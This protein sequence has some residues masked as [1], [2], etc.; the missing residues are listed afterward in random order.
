MTLNWFSPLP[1]ARSAIASYTAAVLP[2]LMRHAEVTVWSE[3]AAPSFISPAERGRQRGGS[4]RD[5]AESVAVCSYRA[6]APP[7][8]EI[9]R[10]DLSIYHI[11]NHA[12]F[13]G[14]IWDLSRQHPGI[15]VL[16]DA[17]LQELAVSWAHLRS[18]WG[19]YIDTMN[20]WHGPSA[21]AAA[22]DV[23]K[24]L[25]QPGALIESFPLT[26][27]FV[28]RALGVVVHSDD[29]YRLVASVYRGP[30]V[31]LPLAFPARRADV[32]TRAWQPPFRLIMFGFLGGNRGLET[33]LATLA[34]LPER[35]SFHLDVYGDLPETSRWQEQIAMSGLTHHVTLH[36]FVSDSAL[37]DA[38][39]RA[40]MVL[41]LRDPP[42]GEA[43]YSLLQAWDHG[44]P[45]IVSNDGWFGELPET[46]VAFARHGAVQEDVVQHLHALLRTPDTYRDIGAA[47]RARLLHLH[48][49]GA[50]ADRLYRFAAHAAAQR[51][52]SNALYMADRTAA[53]VRA[54]SG[55]HVDEWMLQRIATAIHA[56]TSRRQRQ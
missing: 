18:D 13:H 24:G 28:D 9:T 27:A 15:V 16:H 20:R 47:G 31:H 2:E 40:H 11:G 38:L 3:A 36:G 6:T 51:S 10:A 54:V 34:A 53:A 48:T 26:A 1:P 56:L 33:I 43:S 49:P 52:R 4:E 39:D 12:L 17:R 5:R 45:A 35:E 50:Y 37:A 14:G 25:V 46:C 32:V 44:L 21:A 41:N 23:R 29:A 42:R 22:E 8:E 30:L 7:W 19:G 55:P